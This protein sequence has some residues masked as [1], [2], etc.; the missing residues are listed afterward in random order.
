VNPEHH[1]DHR[2][3]SSGGVEVPLVSL[4][5]LASSIDGPIRFI[6]IDVQGYEPSV[7]AGMQKLLA[8]DLTISTEIDPSGLRAFGYSIEDVA[9]P[10]RSAGFSPHRVRRDGRLERLERAED[11]VDQR[12][13][14]EAIWRRG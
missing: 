6:K 13:Y 1:G 10:L 7:L 12:G 4:D 3:T 11:V 14:G 2:V 9:L 8:S 5:A